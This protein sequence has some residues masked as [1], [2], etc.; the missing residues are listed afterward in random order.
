MQIRVDAIDSLLK[1]N[2]QLFTGFH[3]ADESLSFCVFYVMWVK[4]LHR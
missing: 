2:M 3:F 4:A 1:M